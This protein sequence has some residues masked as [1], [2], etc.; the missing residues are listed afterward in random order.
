M[1]ESVKFA[2]ITWSKFA[3]DSDR[4]AYMLADSDVYNMGFGENNNW[5]NSL[6]RTKLNEE[7]CQAVALTMCGMSALVIMWT[8]VGLAT[9]GRCVRFVLLSLQSLYL[10]NR[11]KG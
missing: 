8:A 11:M 5:R 1:K 2:G 4:N 6:V 3:E 9:P 7:L 10:V